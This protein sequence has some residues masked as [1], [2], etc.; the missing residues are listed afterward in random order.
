MTVLAVVVFLLLAERVVHGY[1]ERRDL[2]EREAVWSRERQSFL[3]RLEAKTSGEFA[4]LERV[5]QPKPVKEPSEN[6]MKPNE[7]MVGL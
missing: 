3:N 4:A 7:H 2:R 5:H 6:G 1:L